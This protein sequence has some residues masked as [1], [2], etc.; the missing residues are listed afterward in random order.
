V[1]HDRR[2]ARASFAVLAAA[3]ALGV[4]LARDGSTDADQSRVRRD[5]L[6]IARQG[7]RSTY[8]AD[9]NT[10]RQRAGTGGLS[11]AVRVW[12]R[13]RP[14]LDAEVSGGQLTVSTAEGAWI[15]TSVEQAPTCLQQSATSA[16]QSA[17]VPYALAIA[18]K[19][20][21][22]LRAAGQEIAGERAQCFTLRL[23]AHF[24]VIRGLGTRLDACFASDGVPLSTRL[25]HDGVVD[26]RRA[27]A[28][29]R[30]LRANDLQ[31]LASTYTDGSVPALA[32]R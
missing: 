10:T 13:A 4:G 9:Y 23:R 15:C 20:Y 7:D 8:R 5:L 28:V 12:V 31:T 6:Q 21:D 14:A 29:T 11:G 30:G 26:V 22:V 19:R 27:R 32:R 1:Q 18:S 2:L 17:A 3:M 24:E 16:L 25:E